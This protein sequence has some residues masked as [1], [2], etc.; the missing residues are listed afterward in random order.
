[1]NQIPGLYI[2]N[3]EDRGRCVFTSVDIQEGDTIEIC[4][5][6]KIPSSQLPII[7]K[8]VLHDYYFLWGDQM[9]ECAL[10]LGFGSLYNHEIFANADFIL[11]IEN[12]T[13][14]II[15]ISYIP[16]HTEITINYHGES[17]DDTPLWF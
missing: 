17:G 10:A 11:D 2:L 7:H 14:D 8:T 4:P 9:D 13:I 12:N 1:M 15:A 3:N 5:I 16:A 6:I